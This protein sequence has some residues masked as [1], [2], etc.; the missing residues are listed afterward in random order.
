[1]KDRQYIL[2]S[3]G[4]QAK[5]TPGYYNHVVSAGMFWFVFA[6]RVDKRG[7]SSL[8]RGMCLT[9]WKKKKKVTAIEKISS[10]ADKSVVFCRHTSIANAVFILSSLFVSLET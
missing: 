7:P 9:H 8:K 3:E 4:R 1:M 2:Q 6:L 5:P 10:L